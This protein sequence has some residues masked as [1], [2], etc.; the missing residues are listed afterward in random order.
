MSD[1][2]RTAS[3]PI[4]A[5][6]C[7]SLVETAITLKFSIFGSWI[8]ALFVF[9]DYETRFGQQTRFRKQGERF[10]ILFAQ[11]VRRVEKDVACLR[12]RFRPLPQSFERLK[13][14]DLKA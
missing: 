10:V 6:S 3:K 8:K 13:S 11:P 7:I 4:E 9:R 1:E 12:I 2:L 14:R 5:Q